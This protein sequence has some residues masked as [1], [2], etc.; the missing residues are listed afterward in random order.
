MADMN[1]KRQRRPNVRL[2]EIGEVSTAALCGTSQRHTDNWE[3]TKWKTKAGSLQEVVRQTPFSF[4]R[5]IARSHKSASAN[6]GS[7]IN[8]E[9]QVDVPIGPEGMNGF[10]KGVGGIKS[11]GQEHRKRSLELGPIVK[12][13]RH[14]KVR[15]RGFRGGGLG[16]RVWRSAQIGVSIDNEV[17]ECQEE[18]GVGDHA[19][20]NTSY[21]A[22]EHFKDSDLETLGSPHYAK[23]LG[24]AAKDPSPDAVVVNFEQSLSPPID[25]EWVE[26]LSDR[27]GQADSGDYHMEENSKENNGMSSDDINCLELRSGEP[28]RLKNEV[29]GNSWDQRAGL[30]E[31]KAIPFSARVSGAVD[32]VRGWLDE[33]GFG[34][35]AHIF[36]IH[37]VDN[38]VLPFLT[39]EDLKEMGINAV[40]PRRKIFTAIQMLKEGYSA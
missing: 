4:S 39:F 31:K 19:A 30:V 27:Q 34:K 1:L 9:I 24:D 28:S 16:D 18:D 33:L 5:D 32:S 11:F 20:T 21:D 36:E 10:E 37:E 26:P 17:R 35:Y 38:E 23:E 15:G 8:G 22:Q 6:R 12:K 7:L 29:K 2:G 14:T 3:A 25:D 13:V 40:G